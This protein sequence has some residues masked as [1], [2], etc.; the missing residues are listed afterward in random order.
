MLLPFIYT[1]VIPY[2]LPTC[3]AA[4]TPSS[5]STEGLQSALTS[6]GEGYVLQLCAGE[7]YS[8]QQTLNYTAANQVSLNIMSGGML[9]DFRKSPQRAIQP[10]RLEL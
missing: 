4:C 8:L 9:A 3:S 2:L 5:T 6:G 7:T 10:M 1:L